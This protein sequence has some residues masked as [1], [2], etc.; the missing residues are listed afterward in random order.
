MGERN[1]D[2]F[3]VGHEIAETAIAQRR[4]GIRERR[5]VLEPRQRQRLGIAQRVAFQNSSQ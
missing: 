2:L 5:G 1:E 4:G 3:R